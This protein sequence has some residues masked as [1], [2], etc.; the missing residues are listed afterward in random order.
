[1]TTTGL[2]ISD[3]RQISI[4]TN[5][6]CGIFLLQVSFFGSH[7][8]LPASFS[9]VQMLCGFTG[10]ITSILKSLVILEI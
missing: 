4:I 10:F 5:D 3:N 2:E 8:D 1:M 9:S 7:G 6:F